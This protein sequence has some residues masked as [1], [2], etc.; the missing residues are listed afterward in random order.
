[1]RCYNFNIYLRLSLCNRTNFKANLKIP[2]SLFDAAE[3]WQLFDFLLI[4]M[5]PIICLFGIITNILVVYVVGY[6]SSEKELTKKHYKYMRLN[7]II[8]ILILVIEPFSLI[9][10][11]Q[12]FII[13]YFC[14][15]ARFLLFFQFFKIIFLEYISNVLRM[16][17]NF[18]YFGFAINRLSLIGK[19]HGK[20]VK[21]M[22]ELKVRNFLGIVIGPCLALTVIK[23][24]HSWPNSYDPTYDYPFTSV[25]FYVRLSDALIFVLLSFE[26]LFNLVNYFV[27]IVVNLVLDILLAVRMKRT[28]DEKNENKNSL[29]VK[30]KSETNINNKNR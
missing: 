3:K 25:N 17:S 24:F 26:F 13:G 28:L 14:S 2:A 4:I 9:T 11:C 19:D 20:F 18:S 5:M 21:N 7:S 23:I 29:T 1:M 27:F 12:G 6:K 22:S 30:L 10:E 8:N 15:P 16:L